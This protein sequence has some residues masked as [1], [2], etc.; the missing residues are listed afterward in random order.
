MASIFSSLVRGASFKGKNKRA[1]A[2]SLDAF[3]G[4][5]ADSKS[6]AFDFR[7]MSASTGAPGA[8]KVA[9]TK[10]T[11]D[12][13]K[14]SSSESESGSESEE[15]GEDDASDDDEG[16]DATES[17]VP[18]GCWRCLWLSVCLLLVFVCVFLC[19]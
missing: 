5:N 15:E 17:D 8:E 9:S 19:L 16:D 1:G 18:V 2:G 13:S 14:D 3:K 12:D 10:E 11:E 7:T 6:T 4:S